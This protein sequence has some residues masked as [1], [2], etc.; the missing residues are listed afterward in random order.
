[1]A[2]S[3]HFVTAHRRLFQFRMRRERSVTA[4]GDL[5]TERFG[6]PEN[7][8][9]VVGA[10]Q[11]VEHQRNFEFCIVI[12]CHIYK[13]MRLFAFYKPKAVAGFHF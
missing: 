12:F 13:V 5:R 7:I 2:A 6:D 10:A 11:P 1:M 4:S 8:T 9:G 3:D